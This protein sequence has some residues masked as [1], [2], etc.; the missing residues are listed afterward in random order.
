MI[1]YSV[2]LQSRQAPA[3]A[4]FIVDAGY[5]AKV[6]S[7]ACQGRPQP[8]FEQR[9]RGCRSHVIG[10][11]LCLKSTK[12]ASHIPIGDAFALPCDKQRMNNGNPTHPYTLQI[13]PSPK[14]D[15]SFGWAIRKHGKM[16]ERSD[17]VFRSEQDAMKNGQEAL[18]RAFKGEAQSGASR[19]RR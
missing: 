13:T 17:R 11:P 18:E 7:T 19:P 9:V 15:G 14:G 5:T 2:C 10:K 6:A 8:Q 16:L 4:G 12:T 1:L 3:R